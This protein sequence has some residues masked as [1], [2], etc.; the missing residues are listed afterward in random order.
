[1]SAFQGGATRAPNQ[2]PILLHGATVLTMDGAGSVIE[3]AEI[4]VDAGRVAALG[5]AITVV[6]GTRLVDVQGCIILPGLIQTHVHLG[7]TFFRGLGEGRA[8]LPWLR[9]RIWPLEAAHD[10]ESAYWA[11]LL[12]AAECL[13]GGTTAIQDIGL[14]PGIRGH[15]EALSESR[16]RATCGKCLMDDG[17]ELPAALR[18]DADATLAETEA[19]GR[20]LQSTNNGRLRYSLNPRFLLSCSDTLWNGVRDLALRHGWPVHTHALEH[21]DETLTVRTLKGCDE[22]EYF[23]T[24]GLLA[25]DLRIAHGVWLE[26]RHY[27]RLA[28]G[29]FGVAHCPS[30]NLKLGSGIAD[31]VALTAAGIPVGIGCD[32]AGC[33]NGLDAL[34]EVR[35]AALLQKQLHGPHVFSGRQTLRLATSE[36]AKVLGLQGEVGSL[37]VGQAADLVVLD[38]ARPELWAPAAADLHD[39]VA[40]SASRA[41]VRHV[42]VAGE[43]LVE[44]GRLTHLDWEMIRRQAERSCRALLSR[45]GLG[46]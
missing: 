34:Q 27:P 15:L 2:R 43:Q 7:Q 8:L 24:Q 44:N 4:L 21:R 37:E 26:S 3:D 11:T 31:V 38:P 19:L 18:E 40:F 13:L 10:D 35:L 20:E 30:A 1:M 9:E 23:D 39:V 14:G 17:D 45:S 32:G 16:L 29:R 6:P 22:I 33:N 36:A 28:S 25:T 42:F 5:R 41:Q 12:G 46:L